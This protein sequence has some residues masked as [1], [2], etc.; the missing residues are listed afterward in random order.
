MRRQGPRLAPSAKS[1]PIF[2]RRLL[3]V[4][5]LL[6]RSDVSEF[7]IACDFNLKQMDAAG[8]RGRRCSA[9]APPAMLPRPWLVWTESS[10]RGAERRSDAKMVGLPTFLWIASP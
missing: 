3:A 7:A 6:T 4:D 8:D 2:S 10:L 1:N 5:A 9:S